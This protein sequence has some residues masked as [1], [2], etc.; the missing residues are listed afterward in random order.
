MESISIAKALAS[1]HRY[2]LIPGQ[3]LLA[4]GAANIIGACFS[5][6]PVTGSFS[7]SAVNDS[8]GAQTP[9]SGMVTSGIMLLTL[10]CLTPLF[11]MLPKFCLAAIVMNSVINLFAWREA[12]HLWKV[13][14]SD[15]I[16]WMAAFLGT[17]FLGVMIGL[18]TAIMLSITIVIY[19]AVFPQVKHIPNNTLLSCAYQSMLTP[20]RDHAHTAINADPLS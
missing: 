1:K 19:E 14:K 9:L 7:R 13:K 4:I 5:C 17:L 20:S 12:M 11:K 16:L 15:F 8:V 18:G 6:Y 3:E 10:T 2:K